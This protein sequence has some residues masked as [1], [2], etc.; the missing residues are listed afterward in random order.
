MKKLCL[1]I[2]ILILSLMLT[3]CYA[4]QVK[5]QETNKPES[6]FVMIEATYGW[7]IVYDKETKVMYAVSY[8]SNGT[9]KFTLLVNSDGTPKLWKGE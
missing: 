6:M 2:V 3:G 4:T 7:R 1:L 8:V 9:G 5:E